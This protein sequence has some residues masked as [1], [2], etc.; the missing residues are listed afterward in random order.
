M[1]S[2]ASVLMTDAGDFCLLFPRKCIILT[3]HAIFVNKLRKTTYNKIFLHLNR[4]PNEQNATL[5]IRLFANIMKNVKRQKYAVDR[6][7][8]IAQIN[9]CIGQNRHG[10]K[11]EA[12]NLAKGMEGVR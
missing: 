5:S 8:N 10:I 11:M 7:K 6:T 2:P 3:F 4:N 1:E 9:S 12:C